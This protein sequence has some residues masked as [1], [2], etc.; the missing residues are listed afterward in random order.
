MTTANDVMTY[1]RRTF[2]TYGR[3]QRQKILYYAQAWH[4]VWHGGSLYPDVI[5]A[6]EMGPVVEDARHHDISM[7]GPMASQ[8]ATPRLT[9]AEKATI[10][11]VFAYYGQF[12]GTQLIART[13][14]ESPWKRHYEDVSP[15]LRGQDTIP[16]EEIRQFY[17]LQA[18]SGTDGPGRPQTT[19]FVPTDDAFKAVL[20]TELG[21]WSKTLELLADR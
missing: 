19:A 5:H 17:T 11:A 4:L 3:V 12:T 21:R 13:H 18:L 16:V 15:F 1:M 2:P 10:D 14:S 9:E 7:D 20:A 8:V 6:Y